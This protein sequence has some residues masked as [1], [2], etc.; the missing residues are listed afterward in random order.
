MPRNIWAAGSEEADRHRGPPGGRL[1]L[2]ALLVVS[3][4][5]LLSPVLRPGGADPAGA[6]AVVACAL[7]YAAV[8]NEPVGTSLRGRL[9]RC[10]VI[11]LSAAVLSLAAAMLPPA[12][13]ALAGPV[14]VATML[15]LVYARSLALVDGGPWA[16]RLFRFFVVML[17][18]NGLAGMPDGRPLLS[19]S[20]SGVGI[21][22]VAA[23]LYALAALNGLRSGWVHHLDRRGRLAALTAS[24]L[25]SLLFSGSSRAFS[26]S[27]PAAA[28]VVTAFLSGAA[29]A[30]ALLAFASAVAVLLS[31]PSAKAMARRRRETLALQQMGD[32]ILGGADPG[33]V[34]CRASS[35][36][37]ELTGADAA[38]IELVDDEG[39]YT[40]TSVSGTGLVIEGLPDSGM[41]A[42][43]GESAGRSRLFCRIPRSSPF[44]RLE[45]AGLRVRS[46]VTAPVHA[47]GSH[48]GLIVATGRTPYSF[49]EESA[50]LLEAF[51][52]QA[53]VA[54]LNYR[55]IRE[56]IERER[57]QEELAIARTVQKGLLPSVLPDVSPFDAAATSRPTREV[58]GDCFDVL[59]LPSGRIGL[60]MADVSGKGAGAAILMSA[61]HSS[62]TTLLGEGYGPARAAGALNT[63]ICRISPE[64][65]FIT[66]FAAVLDRSTGVLEY[67]NAG[68]DPPLL[69]SR[70]GSC[71]ELCDGGLV[72]GVSGDA[73]YENGRVLIEPGSTLALYTDGLTDA[74]AATSAEGR[75]WLA[76][77][78]GNNSDLPAAG[79]LEA[80]VG[81]VSRSPGS[82]A[83]EDDMTLL[84]LKAG[85]APPGRPAG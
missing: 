29:G 61:V 27:D 73:R 77:T 60:L 18:L 7:L 54:L 48:L 44:S 78:M 1:L 11:G 59:R 85:D 21:D 40:I 79:M 4:A 75:R 74:V 36:A 28:P 57:Y 71:S 69:V 68:H 58:G 31:L 6:A 51:A 15:F 83:P 22:P 9:S 67:C 70:D 49:T 14:M 41:G 42:W 50:A 46:L 53:G 62:A 35:L 80:V 10:A 52:G 37:R 66:L 16:L 26:T 64:D 32:L 56:G 38:W 24:A 47:M 72:L 5:A 13:P 30:A 3:A 25:L 34:C 33:K 17:L 65:S 2:P 82:E 81:A 39:R 23:V 55:L 76:R 20:I 8:R 19:A 45:A 12:A 84:L 43:A 63:L